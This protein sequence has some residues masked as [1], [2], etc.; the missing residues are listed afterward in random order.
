MPK[1][2]KVSDEIPTEDIRDD[3]ARVNVYSCVSS[4]S[5][6][7]H[8]VFRVFSFPQSGERESK[9]C[10]RHAVLRAVSAD[11]EAVVTSTVVPIPQAIG[12]VC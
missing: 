7:L 3:G 1:E 4:L 8:P 5:I 6:L 11:C 10:H 9:C 12:A 2:T